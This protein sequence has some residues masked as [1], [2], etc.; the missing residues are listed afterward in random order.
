MKDAGGVAQRNKEAALDFLRL[1]VA[2][3]IEE[4]Y[5]AHADM[6]GRHHNPFFPAG[7]PA[8]QKAML[9]NHVEFPNKEFEVKN[10]VAEGELVAVHSRIVLAHGDKLLAAV[11]LF[12]F[13]GGR[14]VELWDCA[15]APPSDSPNSDGMF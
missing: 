14:I 10:V 12:R 2:G 13:S 8:L 6:K 7:F 11:H 3:R 15:Q 4:A 9:E 5:R 1:V